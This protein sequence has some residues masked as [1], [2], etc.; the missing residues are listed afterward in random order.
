MTVK[1]VLEVLSVAAATM[2]FTLATLGPRWAGADGQSKGLKP[3]IVQP[4]LTSAGCRFSLSTDKAT[5]AAG[6]PLVI[7]IE[8]NNPTDKPVETTVWATVS[9]ASPMVTL[10]RVAPMP[11]I[12]WS[13]DCAVSLAPGETKTVELETGINAPVAGSITITLSDK[14]QMVIVGSANLQNAANQLNATQQAVP[15]QQMVLP[16]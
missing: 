1:N 12:P 7:R 14:A 10:S 6:E 3:T 2:A 15:L 13:G 16:Q 5:Y 9:T 4:Q 8:A 11:A